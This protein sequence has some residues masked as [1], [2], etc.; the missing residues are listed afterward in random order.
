[1]ASGTWKKIKKR[2]SIIAKRNATG[3]I[4]ILKIIATPEQISAVPAK[5]VQNTGTPKN[6]GIM[7]LTTSVKTK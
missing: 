2:N 3:L 4:H 1:M 5:Y 6:F 7:A